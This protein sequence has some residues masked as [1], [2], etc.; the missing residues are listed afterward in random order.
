M[1]KLL[2]FLPVLLL[3][4]TLTSTGIKNLKI[5]DD[6]RPMIL[7]E[8]FGFTHTGHFTITVSS[9]SVISSVG[10]PYSSQLGFF[11]LSEESQIP[12]LIELQSNPSCCVL[13]SE[14]IHLLFTFRDLS[15]PPL[16]FFNQTYPITSPN[17]YSLFFA[18][19]APESKVSMNVRTEL[20]NRDG[21]G[22]EKDYLSAGL[23]QLPSLGSQIIAGGGVSGSAELDGERLR[24]DDSVHLLTSE[25]TMKVAQQVPVAG[26]FPI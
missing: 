3:L 13:D 5:S 9:V 17:E 7:F 14:Y 25:T 12:V 26:D 21:F 6:S 18:N 22:R 16:P 20:Y 24:S 8:R 1:T 11:L 10:F 15:P 4:L 19:C 2:F 23:T